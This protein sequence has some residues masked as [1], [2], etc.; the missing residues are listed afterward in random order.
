MKLNVKDKSVLDVGALIGDTALLFSLK[1]AR[2]IVSIEPFPSAFKITKKNIEDNRVVNVKLLNC[3]VSNDNE[4]FLSL[5]VDEYGGDL[6]ARLYDG[7]GNI[8]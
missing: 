3:A 8:H 1:G 2:L 6:N 5:P 4:G 7:K